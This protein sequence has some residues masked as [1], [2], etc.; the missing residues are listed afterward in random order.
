MGR[1]KIVSPDRDIRAEGRDHDHQDF[2]ARVNWCIARGDSIELQR[3]M[4][5]RKSHNWGK[6][7]DE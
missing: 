4:K 2:N 1:L 6:T 5:R 3:T 7:V